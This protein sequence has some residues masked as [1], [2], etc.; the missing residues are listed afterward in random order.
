VNDAGWVQVDKHTLKTR[1]DNVFAV[2]DA[3]MITLANGKPLPKA[4]TFAHA[5]AE[6]VA[7]R[8]AAAIQRAGTEAEFDGDGYCWIEAGGGSAGF[9]NGHFY[10][11]PDPLVPA[12]KAGRMWHLGKVMF[13]KYWLGESVTRATMRTALKIGAAAAGVPTKL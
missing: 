3:T 10:A 9:A 1:F 11:E 13:E 2:G 4:G 5:E 7:E 6:V 12:P 8:I